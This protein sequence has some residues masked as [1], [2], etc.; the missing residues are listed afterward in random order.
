MLANK[1]V[2]SFHL[3]SVVMAL[4]VAVSLVTESFA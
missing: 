2:L 4:R 1:L 3:N